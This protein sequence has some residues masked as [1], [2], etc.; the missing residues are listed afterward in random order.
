MAVL[1]SFCTSFGKVAYGVIA[2]FCTGLSI[3]VWRSRIYKDRLDNLRF[4]IS[5]ISV[6]LLML[7]Y[8]IADSINS[9][10]GLG[11]QV[12]IAS[13]A[14]LSLNML[15]AGAITGRLIYFRSK[16]SRQAELLDR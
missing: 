3:W 8:I 1:V 6:V 16:K 9:S 2:A 10:L 15:A 13:C 11:Q 14:V 4:I 7:N 5:N 12:S